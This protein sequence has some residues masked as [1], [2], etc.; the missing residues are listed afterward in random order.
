M[1]KKLI[2]ISLLLSCLL[3]YAGCGGGGGST[4]GIGE[5]AP[6][7]A[8]SDNYNALAEP[9]E[10]YMEQDDGYGNI[11]EITTAVDTRKVVTTA[12]F[13]IRTDDF[14]DVMRR[15]DHKIAVSGS[16]IQQSYSSAAN[17]YRGAFANM[18]IRVPASGYG[19]FR[20]FITELDQLVSSS[21]QGEDVTV[22]YYDTEARLA[23]LQAQEARIR[24]FIAQSNNLDEIFRIER[25]LVR[26]STEIEQLTTV[27]NRLDN[28]VA[29]ATIYVE[30]SENYEASIIAA[31]F[32][33]R[34]NNA[35]QGSVD[36]LVIAAQS[37]LLLLIWCWPMLIIAGAAYMI[38]RK[39]KKRRDNNRKETQND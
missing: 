36:N 11:T 34:V 1:R 15:L 5:S 9:F 23:V 10:Y 12:N 14:D 17:E 18:T 38:W 22:Q 19:D 25:E 31:A 24:T 27:R 28:L 37:L 3:L 13:S 4:P 16:Y 35:M 33:E 2:A 29:Y 8:Y 21:E 7:R 39:Y 32:G 20:S 6:S 30:I 26:I